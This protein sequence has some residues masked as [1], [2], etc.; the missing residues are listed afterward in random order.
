VDSNKGF[1]LLEIIIAVVILAI[2]SSMTALNIQKSIKFKAKVERDLE[3]YAGV[4]DALV[5][6]TRDINNAFHWI[7]INEEIKKSM[8]ADAQA[9]GKAPPFGT[10]NP[11]GINSNAVPT[12]KITGFIGDKDSLYLTSLGHERTVTDSKESDQAK[13]GYFIKDVKSVHDGQSTKALIRSESVF[14]DGEV[15]KP[16]KETVLL[17]HIKSMTFKYLGGDDK[18]W[19]N[20]WKTDSPEGD[21]QHNK[22]PDAVEVNIATSRD[23][24]EVSL[25]TIAA[26]HMPNNNSP[27]SSPSPA[28]PST[29]A[30]AAPGAAPKNPFG[31][32]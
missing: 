31:G 6:I 1:T 14:L 4:R 18:E 26:V 13:V 19:V 29:A 2:I 27:G 22:F 9:Q 8:N 30:S 21:V 3:D 5:I 28:N 24:R 7:D 11:Q 23:G 32:P 10:P 15:G 20:S 16:G 12:E 17:E 25:S